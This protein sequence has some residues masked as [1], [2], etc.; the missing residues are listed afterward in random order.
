VVGTSGARSADSWGQERTGHGGQPAWGAGEAQSVVSA[1]AARVARER[2]PNLALD[3]SLLAEVPGLRAKERARV[4][5][6]QLGRGFVR[7]VD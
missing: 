4:S 2:N 6:R 5:E 1:G 3:C 7:A